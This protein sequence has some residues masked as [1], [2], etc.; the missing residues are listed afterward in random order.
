MDLHGGG[1]CGSFRRRRWQIGKTSKTRAV[2]QKI[3]YTMDPQ[4]CLWCSL[5]CSRKEGT[6]PE[7]RVAAPPLPLGKLVPSLP[8]VPSLYYS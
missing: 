8:V 7:L 4:D 5:V 1:G 6:S 3:L 2:L